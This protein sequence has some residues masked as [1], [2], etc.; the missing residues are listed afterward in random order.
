M[1]V[2]F[3]IRNMVPP[4]AHKPGKWREGVIQ[5][6]VTRSCNEACFYCTQGSQLAGKPAMITPELFEQAVISLKDYFGVVGVFGG[7][8]ATHPKFPELCEILAKHIPWRQRGLWCNNPMGH[9]KLMREI[10][11]PEHSNLN[12]HLDQNAYNEF[13]RDWPESKPCGLYDDSRHSPVFGS[14][15]K[16]G[17]SE[18]EMWNRIANCDINRHWSAMVAP[19]RGELRAYF[20]EIAG[21]QAM[22]MQNIEG[23]P[24]TGLPVTEGWWKKPLEDFKNQ[25]EHHCTRCLVPY[26]GLGE[27]AQQTDPDAKEMTTEDYALI[28]H[29]K[30]KERPVEVVSDLYQLQPA[31]LRSFVDYIG[32]SKVPS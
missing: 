32:N 19:F 7:N 4:G 5:I 28:Y 24:D 1:N 13:K 10:F 3:A 23:Y 22:L 11:N 29:P 17:V 27:L 20:C 2:D 8:P 21:A 31:S 25:I 14:P 12:V 16:L 15:S 26:R 18:S 9:G 6:F 30:R